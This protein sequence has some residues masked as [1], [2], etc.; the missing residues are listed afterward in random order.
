MTL[1]PQY[2]LDDVLVHSK[3]ISPY[4]KLTLDHSIGELAN[5]LILHQIEMV[6]TFPAITVALDGI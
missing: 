2:K 6:C 1:Y 4:T 3:K 5:E